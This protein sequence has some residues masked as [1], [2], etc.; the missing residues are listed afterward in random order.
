[1]TVPDRP[2]SLQV[3]LRGG[4]AAAFEAAARW[5][6]L[7]VSSWARE[8]LR[9]AVRVELGD[10]GSVLLR[11]GLDGEAVGEAARQDGGSASDGGG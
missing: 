2:A 10:R 5:A 4:E 11:G 8:R 7:S 6:G 9:T 3:R 1:M